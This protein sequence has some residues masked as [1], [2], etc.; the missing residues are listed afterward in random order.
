MAMTATA[1]HG[2]WNARLSASDIRVG[3]HGSVEIALWGRNLTDKE[4]D[5]AAVDN[6][7]QADRAVVWGEPRSFGVD[8]SYHFQ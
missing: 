8:L 4:Y 6:L 2:L 3:A 1:G 5:A 7:P